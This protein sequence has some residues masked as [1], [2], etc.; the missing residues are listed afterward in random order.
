VDNNDLQTAMSRAEAKYGPQWQRMSQK[1]QVDAI[2]NEL[3]ELD[4]EA[5]AHGRKRPSSGS[6]DEGEILGS[7]ARL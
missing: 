5:V 1:E 3:R 4:R 7:L 6:E 2:Y